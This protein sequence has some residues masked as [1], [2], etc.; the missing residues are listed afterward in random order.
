MESGGSIIVVV[1]VRSRCT[2]AAE[3]VTVRAR[4][5]DADSAQILA[6]C[7]ARRSRV[8]KSRDVRMKRNTAA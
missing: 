3:T 6:T 1:A 2:A 7:N 5:R 8:F 4:T